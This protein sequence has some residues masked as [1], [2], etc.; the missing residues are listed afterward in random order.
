MLL[1][2]GKAPITKKPQLLPII[3]KQILHNGVMYGPINIEMISD[4]HVHVRNRLHLTK[5]Q[6]MDEGKS[7]DHTCEYH[8]FFENLMFLFR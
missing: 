8:N 5:L 3:L 7:F 2:I 4:I 6:C 1:D